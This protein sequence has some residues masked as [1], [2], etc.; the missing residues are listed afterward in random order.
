LPCDVQQYMGQIQRLIAVTSAAT[1]D[2]YS[3]IL[4]AVEVPDPAL[5]WGSVNERGL[6]FTFIPGKFSGG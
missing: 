2:D 5:V 3:V 4:M 6:W 1:L